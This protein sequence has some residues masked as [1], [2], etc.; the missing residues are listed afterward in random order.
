VRLDEHLLCALSAPVLKELSKQADALAEAVG[1]G[2]AA[3][4]DPSEDDLNNV[5]ANDLA[6]GPAGSGSI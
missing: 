4:L 3:R 6:S 5:P 1:T 2:V